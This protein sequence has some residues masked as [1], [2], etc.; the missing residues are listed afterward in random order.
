MVRKTA[1]AFTD[2]EATTTT[3]VEETPVSRIAE[4][5]MHEE[6]IDEAD[7]RSRVQPLLDEPLDPRV[8]KQRKGYGKD[9]N[10]KD[11]MLDYLEWFTVVRQLNRIFGYGKWT[12]EVVD[13]KDMGSSRHEDPQFDG[14]PIVVRATVTLRLH[15]PLWCEY[16]NVGTCGNAPRTKKYV[17]G[18][19]M[20]DCDPYYTWDGYEMAVKG[21]VSDALKRA[22]TA[23][24]DQFGLSLYEKE[25]TA[26][27]PTA[28]APTAANVSEADGGDDYAECE[29]CG[30]EIKGYVSR[31]GKEYTT[32]D[33]VA[34]SKKYANGHVLCYN[35]RSKRK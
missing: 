22:A 8:V 30:K 9:R 15:G 31:D 12:T 3:S 14:V 34:I 33:L 1:E 25:D 28:P 6:E 2:D 21:A 10:G 35:C 13:I 4:S 17:P 32:R 19:G 23:L 20:V 29:D 16:T 11:K 27:E 18:R 26:V 24:G 7:Y 5:L